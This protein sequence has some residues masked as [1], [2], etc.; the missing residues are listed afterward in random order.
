MKKISIGNMAFALAALSGLVLSGCSKEMTETAAVSG[1]KVSKT[2]S[3][4]RNDGF[5]TSLQDKSVLWTEGDKVA[6]FAYGESYNLYDA[7]INGSVSGIN[8]SKAVITAELKDI[9]TPQYVVYPT[10]ENA[11]FSPENKEIRTSVPAEYTIT[12]GSFP[13]GANVAAGKVEDGKVTMQNMMALLKFEL[14]AKDISKVVFNTAAGEALCGTVTI[15][16]SQLRITKVEGEPEVTLLPA[17]GKGTFDAGVYYL[18]VAPLEMKEG[19][20]VRLVDSEGFTAKKIHATTYTP[21]ANKVINLGKQS[22][23]GVDVHV[24]AVQT[25]TPEVNG[26]DII[27]SGNSFKIKYPEESADVKFGIEYSNDACTTWHSITVEDGFKT[28]FDVTI[29]GYSKQKKYHIRSWA[30]Y[31]DDD[32]AYGEEQILNLITGPLT[33]VLNFIDHDPNDLEHSNLKYIGNDPNWS[34]PTNVSSTATRRIVASVEDRFSYRVDDELTVYFSIINPISVSSGY[35]FAN[36][37]PINGATGFCYRDKYI[38]MSTPAIPDFKLDNV[39][40]AL[41][42]NSRKSQMYVKYTVTPPSSDALGN[43]ST[44]VGTETERIGVYDYSIA[45]HKNLSTEGKKNVSSANTE[46]MIYFTTNGYCRQ[47]EYTYV[48]E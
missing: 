12:A 46:H 29:P 45:V 28:T 2:I 41:Q 31:K 3:A 4:E 30:Q 42:N 13:I 43:N 24:G 21:V 9:C 26:S 1:T 27:V 35:Y 32:K 8:G 10:A 39:K 38:F 33:F 6:V 15:D 23:W 34:W 22:E 19:F 44:V 20:Y 48:P 40:L 18:P 17:E 5:K 37:D 14:T 25:G 36:D 47:I 16:A 7:D 11:A